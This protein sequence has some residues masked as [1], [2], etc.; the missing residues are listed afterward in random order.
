MNNKY[1]S[2]GFTLVELLIAVAIVGF[3]SAIAYPNYRQ[4]ILRAHRAEGLTALEEAAI[5]QERYYSNNSTYTTSMALLGFAS[6]TTQNGY[7]NIS[8][9][10]CDTGPN[11]GKIGRCFKLTAAALGVQTDDKSCLSLTMDSSGVQTPANCWR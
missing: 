10:A 11:A 3:L 4:Y 2:L 7:Y 5:R 1:K 8:I 6:S 9:A